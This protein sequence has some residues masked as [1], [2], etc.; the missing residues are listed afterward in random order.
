MILACMMMM[1]IVMHAQTNAVA[2]IITTERQ[3]NSYTWPVN[4]KT[5]DSTDVYFHRST[6]T[7]YV[8]DL[9]IVKTSN[10]T[11]TVDGGC[12]Y[13]FGRHN[14]TTSGTYTDTLT[15]SLGCDSIVTLTVNIT[16]VN[17]IETTD[18][19]CQEYSWREQTLTESN[20]YNDSI[21]DDNGCKSVYTLHLTVKQ[22]RQAEKYDTVSVCNTYYLEFIAGSVAVITE[23]IDTSTQ[24][25]S[26][27][28]AFR[29]Y[30]HPRTATRCFDST[31]YVHINVR[32]KVYKDSIVNACDSYV[33]NDGKKDHTYRFSKEDEITVDTAANG[34][35]S[36]VKLNITIAK[37]PQ[38]IIKGDINIRPNSDAKLVATANQNVSWTWY[39][40][41]RDSTITL[42]GLTENTDVWVRADNEET[43]CSSTQYVTI[44]CNKLGVDDAEADINI[45][46]NPATELVNVVSTDGVKRISLYN[47]NGQ[48]VLTQQGNGEQQSLGLQ[49]L[50]NGT[51]TMMIELGSGKIV[52]RTIII[53]K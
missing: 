15:S 49:T 18:S 19:A 37:T 8:L 34:C 31:Y 50:S 12:S 16:N 1:P 11:A 14:I 42:T 2:N 13:S 5:Y 38:V 46:P 7:L 20:T 36:I 39:D 23:T 45:Y 43:K 52:T 10:T 25:L 21:V 41:S 6:D 22:P 40:G 9:T 4:G 53:S 44:L 24:V 33:F 28:A 29:N 17:R 51:Y 27:R 47:I 26:N 30:Y 3:C 48:R 32:K 35:D